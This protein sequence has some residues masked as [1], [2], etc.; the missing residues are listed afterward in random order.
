MVLQRVSKQK[1]SFSISKSAFVI[2]SKEK[3]AVND[4]TIVKIKNIAVTTL[5]V[6]IALFI[7]P[8]D[9]LV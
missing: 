2:S 1:V 5:I 8:P 4:K 3:Q 7:P 6:L 9:K